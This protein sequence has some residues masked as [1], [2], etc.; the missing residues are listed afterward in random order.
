MASKKNQSH[1]LTCLFCEVVFGERLRVCEMPGWAE[2]GSHIFVAPCHDVRRF[3]GPYFGPPNSVSQVS[4][5]VCWVG[6]RLT[7]TLLVR[8]IRLAILSHG[9]FR[10]AG[11]QKDCGRAR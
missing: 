3:W 8:P 5:S 1:E 6:N 4:P 7:E 9:G 11:S 10:E 2:E